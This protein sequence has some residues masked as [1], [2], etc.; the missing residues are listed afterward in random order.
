MDEFAY[1]SVLLS[2]ILGLAITQILQGCR[3]LVLA[4][5][6][7]VRYPPSLGWA[8]LLLLIDVQTWWAMFGLRTHAH[9]S[10]GA[11][12]IV[13]LQ[14]VVLYLLAALVLPDFPSEGTVDLNAHYHEHAPSFFSLL[15]LVVLISIAKDRVINH[16]L[17][18]VAN[19]VFHAVFF[20]AAL[21]GGFVKREWFHRALVP[22]LFAVFALYVAMLFA[23]LQ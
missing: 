9:W 3:G 21:A 4:G 2:L 22:S 6:R 20:I 8:G 16:E 13:L 7:V 17:P 12:L 18:S 23:Q 1:L 14:T 19:L 5:G 11:F 10:F 15:A